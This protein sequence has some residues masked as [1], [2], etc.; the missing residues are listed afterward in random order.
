LPLTIKEDNENVHPTHLA[1]LHRFLQ[2][3]PLSLGESHDP[4]LVVLQIFEASV[5]FLDLFRL[6]RYLSNGSILAFVK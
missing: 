6:L 2:E 3:V 4:F 5:A 1:K